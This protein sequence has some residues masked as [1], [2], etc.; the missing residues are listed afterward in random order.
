MFTLSDGLILSLYPRSELAKDAGV[1][2]LPVGSAISVG[3]LVDS[4]EEVDRVLELARL[5][6][7][8]VIGAPYDRPWGIYSGYFADPDEHLWEIIHFPGR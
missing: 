2:E 7:A 4:R 1:D 5:A 8:S 6:G 3:H